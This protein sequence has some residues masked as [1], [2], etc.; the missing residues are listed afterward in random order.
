VIVL[1]EFRVMLAAYRAV[2]AGAS[3]EEAAATLERQS[4]MPAWA[5]KLAAAE[6]S[7]WSTLHK[8]AK[9]ILTSWRR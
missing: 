8:A 7:L 2:F 9:S 3:R 6:A 1:I 4:G 5:A